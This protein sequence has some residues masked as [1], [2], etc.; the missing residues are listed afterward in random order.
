MN[1]A[2]GSEVKARAVIGRTGEEGSLKGPILH[3]DV[4]KGT[5][6]L[7][8]VSQRPRTSS[9]GRSHLRASPPVLRF[10]RSA[11]PGQREHQRDI[12]EQEAGDAVRG[13]GR[14]EPGHHTSVQLPLEERAR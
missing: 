9:W 2:S 6:A 8:P 12:A 7:D 4:R 3:F 11:W 5:A 1:L 13:D 14:A 10:R